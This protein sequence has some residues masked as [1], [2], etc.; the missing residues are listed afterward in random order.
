MNSGTEAGLDLLRL[1][2]LQTTGSYDEGEALIIQVQSRE[3]TIRQCCLLQKLRR[4]GTKT[5]R[6]R[7]HAI[8]GQTTFLEY[9][10]QRWECTSCGDKAVYEVVPDLHDKRDMTKRF[11]DHLFKHATDL[12]FSTAARI[13]G[14]KETM[15]R[16]V[17]EEQSDVIL[18]GYIPKMPR[19]LGMDELYLEGR[20]RF[21]IGDVENSRM[22]DMQLSRR[23]VDLRA[24]FDT[25]LDRHRVEVVT[26]DM[27]RGYASITKSMFPY[28]RTVVD[29][30]HVQRT[31]NFGVEFTRKALYSSLSASDRVKLKRRNAL[32][33]SRWD[34]SPPERQA[35]LN[36]LFEQYPPL[37]EAY[38]LKERF[39]DIYYKLDRAEAE[40]RMTAWAMSVPSGPM[41]RAFKQ[42]LDAIKNW[43]P[44]ILRYFEYPFTN[45]YVEGLNGLVRKINIIGSGYSFE[46]LRKKALLKYGSF[47][48]ADVRDFSETPPPGKFLRWSP[49]VL[50]H[51]RVGL[52]VPLSTF[53]ADFEAGRF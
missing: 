42:S 5:S 4:N 50:H 11:H 46:T 15:V 29:K 10:R 18:A 14:V 38:D 39:Y 17:F 40:R 7:D 41:Q 25:F 27:W 47:E 24:Y 13:N 51:V 44:H 28:A 53:E 23:D 1:P 30:Y 12:P 16:R 6:F 48:D 31:A 37:R 34:N 21:V 22:L 8:Q 49:E 2:H 36:K 32:F 20:P 9:R 26:Q 45:A 19:I 35:R 3:A 33:L 43:R 52:G